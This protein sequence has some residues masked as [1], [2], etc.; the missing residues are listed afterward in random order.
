MLVYG[1][2]CWT[3]LGWGMTFEKSSYQQDD[4][5]SI[6]EKSRLNYR[7]DIGMAADI[8]YEFRAPRYKP[9]FQTGHIS[10]FNRKFSIKL[11]DEHLISDGNNLWV[12]HPLRKEVSIHRLGDWNQQNMT[13]F[14]YLVFNTPSAKRLLG[15]KQVSGVP[16]YHISVRMQNPDLSFSQAVIWIDAEKFL[17]RKMSFVSRRQS[18]Q[19][20][21]FTNLQVGLSLP[22]NLFQFRIE[23]Y[24]GTRVVQWTDR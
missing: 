12:Y 1:L 21:T 14:L 18:V 15:I 11:Q 23:D 24:P 3:T 19:T 7:K 6:L 17:V 20:Y 9:V 22:Q 2:I 5:V 16:C 4:A 10:Y 8:I 13:T